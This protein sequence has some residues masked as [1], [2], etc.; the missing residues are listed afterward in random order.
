MTSRESTTR[1]PSLVYFIGAAV[2]AVAIFGSLIALSHVS[3]ES[4]KQQTPQAPRQTARPEPVEEVVTSAKP[5]GS[6]PS[7]GV[8]AGRP[9]ESSDPVEDFEHALTC[10]R[11]TRLQSSLDVMNETVTNPEARSFLKAGDLEAIEDNLDFIRANEQKCKGSEH[12][13][14]DGTIYDIA[15]RAALAGSR[16]AAN[17]YTDAG[18]NYSEKQKNDPAEFEKY[19]RHAAA[20]IE[21]GIRAGDWN[22]VVLNI[23]RYTP[24]YVDGEVQWLRRINQP[25]ESMAYTYVM[26][27]YLGAT[28][29]VVAQKLQDELGFY[30]RSLTPDT[31]GSAKRRAREIYEQNFSR[32]GAYTGKEQICDL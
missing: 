19:R 17:C 15:L 22:A 32:S 25:D 18:F 1:R 29:P 8:P 7:S 4:E 5:S 9:Q 31:L 6:R 13:R 2:L 16:K 3:A 14:V 24:T 26:V 12:L 28:D 30:E 21:S 11:V 10:V 27:T 20:F 23:Q